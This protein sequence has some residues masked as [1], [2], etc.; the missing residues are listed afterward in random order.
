[1]TDAIPFA[2][3]HLY[4]EED[5][6]LLAQLADDRG[7]ALITTEKDA[8]RLSPEWRARVLTLPVAARFEDDAALAALLAPIKAMMG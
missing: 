2:D 3:H 8:A 4:N 1:L 6:Q 7:A 5:M